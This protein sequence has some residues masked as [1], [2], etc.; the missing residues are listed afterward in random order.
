V[1]FQSAIY[2][3]TAESSGLL[4]DFDTGTRTATAGPASR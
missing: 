4:L 1:P 3:L 2:E